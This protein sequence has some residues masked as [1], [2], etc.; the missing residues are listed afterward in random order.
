MELPY[1]DDPVLDTVVSGRHS[2]MFKNGQIKYVRILEHVQQNMID[3]KVEAK[4]RVSTEYEMM[5]RDTRH[6][7]PGNSI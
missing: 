6:W 5:T 2:W 1:G 4:G 3:G 7:I